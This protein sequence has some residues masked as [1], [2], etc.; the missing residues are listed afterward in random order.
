MR[1]SI[2]RTVPLLVAAGCVSAAFLGS[3]S[4]SGAC[5]PR[6]SVPA[7]GEVAGVYPI[8]YVACA[9][10]THV[11]QLIYLSGSKTARERGASAG[12]RT[13]KVRSVGARTYK[14]NGSASPGTY[15]ATMK[16]PNGK[17]VRSRHTIRIVCGAARIADPENFPNC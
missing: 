1:Y 9:K 15:R 17:R 10:G 14:W 16:L 13:I 6:V 4:A 2:S 7:K 12:R 3:S 11:L 8:K 5:D